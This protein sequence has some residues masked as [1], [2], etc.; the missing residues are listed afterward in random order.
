[1]RRRPK[2]HLVLNGLLAFEPDGRTLSVRTFS[3]LRLHDGRP[4]YWDDPRWRF[5]VD[6][7]G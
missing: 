1:M 5:A 2:L 7:G 4:H 6:L 3:P